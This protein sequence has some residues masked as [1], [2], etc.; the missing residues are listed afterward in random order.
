MLDMQSHTVLLRLPGN[1]CRRTVSSVLSPSSSL[2]SLSLHPLASLL[3]HFAFKS[4]SMIG[5]PFLYL[6]VRHTRVWIATLNPKLIFLLHR[7][8]NDPYSQSTIYSPRGHHTIPAE[9]WLG[10]KLKLLSDQSH[11]FS[12][13]F[14]IHPDLEKIGRVGTSTGVDPS[15]SNANNVSV[16]LGCLKSDHGVRKALL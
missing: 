12:T 16:F 4:S 15:S 1:S 3:P 5:K 6:S 8:Y 7:L 2:F 10:G 11:S 9:Q 13:P 14:Q